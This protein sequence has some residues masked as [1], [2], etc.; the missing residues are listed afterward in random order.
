M[1]Q[2][3]K[4]RHRVKEEFASFRG[5]LISC[6]RLV[7]N[8]VEPNGLCVRLHTPCEVCVIPV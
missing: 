3:K 4:I 6:G 2:K 8:S 1:C 7:G 5:V